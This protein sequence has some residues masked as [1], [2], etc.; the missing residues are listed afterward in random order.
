MKNIKANYLIPCLGM[1]VIWNDYTSTLNTKEEK[2]LLIYHLLIV[3]LLIGGGIVL[4]LI[5]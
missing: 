2:V 3:G 1:A 5:R 4:W